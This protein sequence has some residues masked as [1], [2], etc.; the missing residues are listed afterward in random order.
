MN[1][2]T[3]HR[4]HKRGKKHKRESNR[5][6]T[7]AD[8]TGPPT[9]IRDAHHNNAIITD[10]V[11]SSTKPRSKTIAL[12]SSSPPINKTVIVDTPVNV[13]RTDINKSSKE[14][15]TLEGIMNESGAG[16]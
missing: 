3:G 11:S 7:D 2:N 8:L 1:Q 14:L 12:E 4:S 6:K 9:F 16:Q 5:R 13:K 15:E 10:K